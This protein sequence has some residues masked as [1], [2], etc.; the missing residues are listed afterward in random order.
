MGTTNYDFTREGG[1]KEQFF[2]VDFGR[3]PVH[4]DIVSLP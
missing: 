2:P 3:M 4:S 1:K